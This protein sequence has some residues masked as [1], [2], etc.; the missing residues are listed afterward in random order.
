MNKHSPPQR[1]TGAALALSDLPVPFRVVS[2]IASVAVLKLDQYRC[3]GCFEV[4][5]KDHRA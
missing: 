1:G 5:R 4:L 3:D 2:K